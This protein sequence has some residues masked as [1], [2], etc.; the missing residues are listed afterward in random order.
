MKQFV[1]L[2]F[3]EQLILSFRGAS[4]VGR[5]TR[6]SHL[7]ECLGGKLF[8]QC[9][10]WWEWMQNMV[11]GAWTS[12]IQLRYRKILQDRTMQTEPIRGGR[13]GGGGDTEM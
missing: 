3:V 7:K 8:L 5:L 6:F 9:E 13:E 10:V 1:Y 11:I 2:V 12:R 4:L